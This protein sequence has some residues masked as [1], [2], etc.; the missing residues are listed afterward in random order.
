MYIDRT[1]AIARSGEDI[2]EPVGL[3]GWMIQLGH[4]QAMR[5]LVIYYIV[6]IRVLSYLKEDDIAELNEVPNKEASL[7]W[8]TLLQEQLL[9]RPAVLGQ[10]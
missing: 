3:R 6:S 7:T 4:C 10:H 2:K 8:L 5:T 1:E 9:N